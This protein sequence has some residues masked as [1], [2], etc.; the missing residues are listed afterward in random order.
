[1][2]MEKLL[3]VFWLVSARSVYVL[4]GSEYRADPLKLITKHKYSW[5]IA[6]MMYNLYILTGS[7]QSLYKQ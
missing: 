5:P 7:Q 6:Y 3:W 4:R 1:M 2:S